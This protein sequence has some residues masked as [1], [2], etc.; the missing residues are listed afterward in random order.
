MISTEVA[1]IDWGIMGLTS[2]EHSSRARL[3]P[4]YPINQPGRRRHKFGPSAVRSPV[5]GPGRRGMTD[6]FASYS[7]AGFEPK[8][9]RYS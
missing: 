6:C 5:A 3:R 1:I 7:S 2:D 9:R 8:R 4:A